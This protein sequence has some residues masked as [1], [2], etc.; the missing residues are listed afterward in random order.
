LKAQ[1]IQDSENPAMVNVGLHV[2]ISGRPG[3]TVAV[4][5]FLKYVKAKSGAW[6]ERRVD[7]AEWWLGHYPP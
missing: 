1:A 2:R 5:E 7:I 6:I 4:E 3:R